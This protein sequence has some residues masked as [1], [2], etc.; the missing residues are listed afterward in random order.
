MLKIIANNSENEVMGSRDVPFSKIIYI[1]KDDFMEE[2]I[3]GFN[4]LTPNIELH[5]TYG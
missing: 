3:K 1:E 4:I 5:C 2:A